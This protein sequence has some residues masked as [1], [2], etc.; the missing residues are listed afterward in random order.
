MNEK[1]E[2][3]GE[4]EG[5]NERQQKCNDCT[6]GCPEMNIYQ[7]AYFLELTMAACANCK[8]GV[9]R[10]VKFAETFNFLE[11]KYPMV[12][13][14]ASSVQLA[15]CL[16]ASVLL[17]IEN[18]EAVE[19]LSIDAIYYYLGAISLMKMKQSAM[20]ASVPSSYTE[21]P[22]KGGRLQ[23]LFRQQA[24]RE[25]QFRT[26]KGTAIYLDDNLPCDCLK[27][28]RAQLPDY[29]VCGRVG[30]Y[31]RCG[32]EDMHICSNCDVMEYC[33][34]KCQLADWPNHKIMCKVFQGNLSMKG[35]NDAAEKAK[36][37]EKS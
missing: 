29:G 31:Q 22:K 26:P 23:K 19:W 3:S 15:T 1:N 36:K 34:R 9:N 6:H 35:L 18:L 16:A 32:V 13:V 8:P 27:R 37:R 30:C 33:S 14:D 2:K 28:L 25:V 11:A 12:G 7:W 4:V 20:K 21:K 10:E 24:L 17:N 5:S